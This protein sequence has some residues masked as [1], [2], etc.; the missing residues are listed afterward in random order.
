MNKTVQISK[1]FQQGF[2]LIE[3]L[4]V[5]LII[6]V[7]A[8][9]LLILIN[10]VQKTQQAQDSSGK[11]GVSSVAQAVESFYSTNGGTAY[12]T[13]L[14]DLTNSKD[15]QN[16]PPGVN[17]DSAAAGPVY[18]CYKELAP[19]NPG[20]A[21]TYFE[22]STGGVSNCTSALGAG[23]TGECVTSAKLTSGTNCPH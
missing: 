8:A 9:G 10:P 6:G 1:K 3:L 12:P 23:A 11:S 5:I 17:M 21:G 18:V 2:T 7:L 20:K 16:L 14:S 15:L 13:A 19:Q 4:V 22:W